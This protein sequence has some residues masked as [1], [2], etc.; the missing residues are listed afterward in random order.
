MREEVQLHIATSQDCVTCIMRMRI[1]DK[2]QLPIERHRLRNRAARQGW[3]GLR[4]YVDA[5]VHY[6]SPWI[7]VSEALM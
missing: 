4:L 1:A 5:G 7:H 6:Q 2:A 3:D